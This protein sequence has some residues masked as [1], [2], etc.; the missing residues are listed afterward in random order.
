MVNL[1][2]SYVQLP[3]CCLA[4]L[5]RVRKYEHGRFSGRK[6]VVSAAET[7]VS[8]AETVVSPAETAVS[9][10]ETAVSPAE[11]AVS[12]AETV[13]SVAEMVVSPPKRPFR[14]PKRPFR[15]PKGTKTNG[16][17]KQCKS[18]AKLTEFSLSKTLLRV[19]GDPDAF[20]FEF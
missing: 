2:R 3:N 8:A 17:E 5:L 12:A 15:I 19:K 13:V 1:R 7:D 18:H 16:Y 6:T 9:P 11:T 4:Y 20:Y 14:T 10:A